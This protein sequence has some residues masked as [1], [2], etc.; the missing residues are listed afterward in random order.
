[1][2]LSKHDTPAKKKNVCLLSIEKFFATF[3]ADF[4]QY[5]LRKKI[6]CLT[7]L[8]A[9]KGIFL[10]FFF[11]FFFFGVNFSKFNF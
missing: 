5:I 10:F 9:T 11:V 1:M 8:S 7:F 6:F 4:T 3:P 2:L